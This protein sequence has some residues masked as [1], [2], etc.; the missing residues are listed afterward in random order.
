MVPTASPT[1]P[2]PTASTPEP[3]PGGTGRCEGW[4]FEKNCGWTLETNC[5]G[6]SPGSSGWASDDG[7]QGYEC[8]CGQQLWK[9]ANAS[10]APS[11]VS[12]PTASPTQGGTGRCEGWTFEK[13]CGWTLE[14]NCPGQSPGS[15]GWASDDG[16]QGYELTTAVRGTSAAAGS[17]FGSMRTRHWRRHR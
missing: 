11:P 9:H 10:L 15:S 16:G 5:P 1:T 14:T 2:A 12:S 8:C 7:G 4:T 13:N 3:T 17:S 6:Q